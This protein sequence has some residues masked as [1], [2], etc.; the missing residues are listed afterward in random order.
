MRFSARNTSRPS[1]TTCR[2]NSFSRPVLTMKPTPSGDITRIV[3][4]VLLIGLLIVGTFWTL[5][6]F[7]GAL[8]WATTLV[9]ATWPLMLWVQRTTGGRRGVAVAIMTAL[10][11]AILI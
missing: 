3:L 6:P 2:E 8:I 10:I 1:R 11:L 4:I 9:V 5:A 7:L